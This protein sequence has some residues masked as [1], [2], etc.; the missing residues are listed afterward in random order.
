MPQVSGCF[1]FGGARWRTYG[2]SYVWECEGEW[3]VYC[4]RLFLISYIHTHTQ[5]IRIL[6]EWASDRGGTSKRGI[7]GSIYIFV[8]VNVRIVYME[9]FVILA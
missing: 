4:F 5:T 6:R 2:R 7:E 3:G 8:Y 1:V 9:K